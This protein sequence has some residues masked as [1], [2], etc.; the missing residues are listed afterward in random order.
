MNQYSAYCEAIGRDC[1]IKAQCINRYQDLSSRVTVAEHPRE[2]AVGEFLKAVFSMTPL[3][4][5]DQLTAAKSNLAIVEAV[6]NL[7]CTHE[8]LEHEA[9]EARR[10]EF[11]NII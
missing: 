1:D 11:N 7:N 4:S 9:L 8:C 6:I 2:A 3:L 5:S 10:A